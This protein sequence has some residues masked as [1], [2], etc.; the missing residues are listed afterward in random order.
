MKRK[1]AFLLQARSV[2]VK[3]THDLGDWTWLEYTG[4]QK[5]ESKTG[6]GTS[7]LTPFFSI[8]IEWSRSGD[9]ARGAEGHGGPV[10]AGLTDGEQAATLCASGSYESRRD[11]PDDRALSEICGAND[12][13]LHA[14]EDLLGVGILYRGNELFLKTD[15][16][17]VWRT[18]KTMIGSLEDRFKRGEELSPASCRR[19]TR[20]FGPV[21]QTRL[22]RSPR[23]ASCCRGQP[24]GLPKS[25]NQAAYIQALRSSEMVFG[26]GPAGTGK[27]YLAVA[28]LWPWS[29]PGRSASWS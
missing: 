22:P 18:F 17:S 16:E 5:L 2:S 26:I 23:P 11:C 4:S 10:G 29:C 19:S 28:T 14:L 24:E 25:P 15:D 20:P 3:S 7:T 12:Q 6:A 1:G 13:N 9:T 21:R 8:V 27:T